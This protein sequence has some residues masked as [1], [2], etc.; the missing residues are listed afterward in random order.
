MALFYLLL[1]R[2]CFGVAWG[3]TISMGNSSTVSVS[4][5]N[6]TT[7]VP[8]TTTLSVASTTVPQTTT[9]SVADTT[10][11]ETTTLS[12]T[13]AT[14]SQTTASSVRHG[15]TYL[16][17]GSSASA[18]IRGSGYEI[19]PTTGRN[20]N[21][22]ISSTTAF[23]L[24]NSTLESNNATRPFATSYPLSNATTFNSTR[25][26]TIDP[27]GSGFDYASS[28]EFATR[29]W[30]STSKK[31][32]SSHSYSSIAVN[33]IRKT[34]TLYGEDV[35]PVTR[36]SCLGQSREIGGQ[37]LAQSSTAETV[38]T[39]LYSYLTAVAPPYTVPTP[40]CTFDTESC[41]TL[42]DEYDAYWRL[43]AS[44]WPAA[45]TI[46]RVP[47]PMCSP[48]R[49][50]AACTKCT[51]EGNWADVYYWPM[52]AV[53]EPCDPSR[54][55][56]TAAPTIPGQA[57]TIIF[58]TNTFT[59]PTVYVSIDWLKALDTKGSYCG[60]QYSSTFLPLRPEEVSSIRFSVIDNGYATDYY[61][62]DMGT[63]TEYETLS[64]RN[65]T[66]TATA[67]VPVF[68]GDFMGAVPAAAYSAQSAII[69][70]GMPTTDGVITD[71]KYSPRLYLPERVRSMDPYWSNCEMVLHGIDDPP[72]AL[73][74][75]STI[76]K[77]VLPTWTTTVNVPGP[78]D[79]P[80]EPAGQP[81]TP[82]ASSTQTAASQSRASST[83]GPAE[84]GGPAEPSGMLSQANPSSANPPEDGQSSQ[85]SS[86][87]EPP[88]VVVIPAPVLPNSGN[89]NSG[90][91]GIPG[92]IA[93]SPGSG[94]PQEGQ[95]GT[96]NQQSITRVATSRQT[97]MTI[98]LGSSTLPVVQSGSIA[99]VG[100]HTLTL[101]GSAVVIQGQQISLEPSGLRVESSE[102]VHFP[103]APTQAL[104]AT[105]PTTAV[106]NDGDTRVTVFQEKN[107]V[108]LN[109]GTQTTTIAFGDSAIFNGHR[110]DVPFSGGMVFIDDSMIVPIT[111][112]IPSSE[113]VNQLSGSS[114][115]L[116]GSSIQFSIPSESGDKT[117][118][119]EILGDDR[120]RLT[121]GSESIVV[122]NGASAVLAG[123]TVTIL[124]DGSGVVVSG[125]SLIP[126][127]I[128]PLP[129]SKAIAAQKFQNDLFSAV[130]S[131]RYIL[132]GDADST[133]TLAD[134]AVTV[135]GGYTVSAAG[136]GSYVVVDGSVAQSVVSSPT[137]VS[138]GEGGGVVEDAEATDGAVSSGSVGP[139]ISAVGIWTTVLT[140]SVLVCM[141][142]T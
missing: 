41:N 18:T 123:S 26:T 130:D 128:M 126:L 93:A 105:V 54:S 83:A 122:A 22:T 107:S 12:V 42:W 120:I 141:M 85:E 103:P 111:L 59:S 135:I 112:D 36:T 108:V 78:S 71:A 43:A 104:P 96:T 97:T 79:I 114:I 69:Y 100:D 113:P 142:M 13:N 25:I 65:V 50:A 72:V 45:P 131:G 23:L 75:A 124:A 73:T 132:V 70:P 6:S 28:C 24:S 48:Y 136:D 80:A 9:L 56:I 117:I 118:T 66:V 87:Q 46:T 5:H 10:V 95:D 77:P 21:T 102:T 109:S 49:P 82:H 67:T 53:G 84:T 129:Q 40:V 51:I 35:V 89:Q 62:W 125:T 8:Q 106:W 98:T 52:E 110:V 134:G 33:T 11:S 76:V 19:S 3:L 31:W 74:A 1:F 47:T 57:N 140:Y 137:G 91:S 55:F 7:A 121:S 88:P 63:T 58:G 38:D 39:M 139:L 15:G 92:P 81:E 32:F 94:S 30:Q 99:D 34:E 115:P 127:P 101:G 68:F 60:G 119:A 138:E 29:D 16:S 133:L 17:S 27:T 37:T 116:P 61:T 44:V 20:G 4:Y 86:P 2:Y 14:A 90:P 64:T